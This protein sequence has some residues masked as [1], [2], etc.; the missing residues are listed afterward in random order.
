MTLRRECRAFF[1][2]LA[3]VAWM[4]ATVV[5]VAWA[6]A[7]EIVDVS[8]QKADGKTASAPGQEAQEDTDAPKKKKKKKKKAAKAAG[9]NAD[10]PADENGDGEG[11]NGTGEDEGGKAPKHPSIKIGDDIR[12]EVAMRIEGDLRGATPDIGREDAALEWQDRRI[13]IQGTAFKRVTFEISREFT[14]DFDGIHDLG[15]KTPWKDVYVNYRVSKALNVQVG[16]FKLPFGHEE[17]VGET[18]RDFTY[19]SLPA[20]VLSPGRDI[21]A[22]LHGRVFKKRLEY[23][24][25]YFQKDGDNGRTSQTEGGRGAYAGRVLTAPFAQFENDALAGIKLGVAV[26]NSRVDNRYGLRGRTVLGDGIFFDRVYVNGRRQ[27]VGFEGSWNYGPFS[28]ASEYISISDQRTGMD[29]DGGDLPSV[30]Q[31][32]WYVSGSWAITGEHKKGRITPRKDVFRGGL[33]AFELVARV[34]KLVFDDIDYPGSQFGVPSGGKLT[35]NSDH[36]TTFG[37]N[38]YLNRYLKIMA[39]VINEQIDDPERSPAPTNDGKFRSVIVRF[40]FRM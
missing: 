5:R 22:M 19:R 8:S 36:V 31:W 34:E 6:N 2:C 33:G 10:S 4:D 3:A 1:V 40:Q 7:R 30:K 14:H 29:F 17:L 35:G 25:G 26:E 28:A 11:D 20:R 32:G 15:E 23:Q 12:L 21:G 39:D 9:Q 38:W 24:F 37:V 18:N 16:R 27:R 13:G